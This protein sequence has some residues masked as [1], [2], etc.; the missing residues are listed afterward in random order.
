MKD[1]IESAE[2]SKKNKHI[3][4]DNDDED[5]TNNGSDDIGGGDGDGGKNKNHTEKRLPSKKSEKNRKNAM[6]IGTQW[7]QVVSY[8]IQLIIPNNT[9][10]WWWTFFLNFQ[11]AEH[12]SDGEVIELKNHEIEE[13][14]NNCRKCYEEQKLSFEKRKWQ[15]GMRNRFK[16][17]IYYVNRLLTLMNIQHAR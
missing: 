1:T 9:V 7:Y 3:K 8:F 12:N 6:E 10:S 4:F 17:A 15:F 16:S 5:V 13:I 14:T 11:F 2:I